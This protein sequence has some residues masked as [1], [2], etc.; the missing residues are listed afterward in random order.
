M[1]HAKNEKRK[2]TNDGRNRTTKSRINQNVRKK[3]TY[4]SLEIVEA[5]TIKKKWR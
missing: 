1:R 3:E 4:K 2:M 5:D